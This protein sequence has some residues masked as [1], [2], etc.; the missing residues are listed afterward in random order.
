[1]GSVEECN[2]YQKQSFVSDL[3]NLAFSIFS[4]REE[5]SVSTFKTYSVSS[6]GPLRGGPGGGYPLVD[7][8]R[9]AGSLGWL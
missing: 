2:V 5:K 6:G 1:M 8:P 9:E 4:W 3:L 7:S